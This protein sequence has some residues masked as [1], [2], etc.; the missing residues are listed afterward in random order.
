MG[1]PPAKPV[2]FARSGSAHGGESVL[3]VF[4][5]VYGSLIFRK[6]SQDTLELRSLENISAEEAARKVG[7]FGTSA[8]LRTL[9]GEIDSA[10]QNRWPVV[11]SGGNG[12]GKRTFATL[13]H[14]L[15]SHGTSAYAT[16]DCSEPCRRV[17]NISSVDALLKSLAENACPSLTIIHAEALPAKLSGQLF[18]ALEPAMGSVRLQFTVERHKLQKFLRRMSTSF[19]GAFEKCVIQVPPICKRREDIKSHILIKLGELNRRF[20]VRKQIAESALNNLVSYD[21]ADNFTGL[22]RTLEWMYATQSSVMNF[23]DGV[24]DSCYKH[25]AS[26]D[27][28][29]L[30]FPNDFNLNN[31]MDEIRKKIFREAIRKSGN[32]MSRAARM[33][34]VSPQAVSN[35]VARQA[36]IT[37]RKEL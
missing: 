17:R 26:N 33:L 35:H 10:A 19:L 5:S 25:S 13:L 32:N 28:Y 36:K 21:F 34:G 20:G 8:A 23:D 30:H 3:D 6:D 29:P 31:F 24:A 4:Y 18:A 27:V 22:F 1:T 16:V 14:R 2:E 11:F 9:L 37:E 12:S 15:T 7:I